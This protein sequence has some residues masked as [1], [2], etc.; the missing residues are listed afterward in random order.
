M[1]KLIGVIAVLSVGCAK[2][3]FQED[4]FSEKVRAG[5][6]TEE[7]CRRLL[8]EAEQRTMTCKD[9]TVGYVRC[10]VA[11]PPPPWRASARR[12]LHLREEFGRHRLFQLPHDAHRLL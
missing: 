7:A 10:D 6:K 9:N 11:R 8:V 3:F 12:D 5:C 2:V 4:G 1:Q